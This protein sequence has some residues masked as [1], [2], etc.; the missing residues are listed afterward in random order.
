MINRLEDDLKR[1]FDLL[2]DSI[3]YSSTDTLYMYANTFS[4]IVYDNLT[5][6]E[7]RSEYVNYLKVNIDKQISKKRDSFNF[8]KF[9]RVEKNKIITTSKLKDRK[10]S[11]FIEKKSQEVFTREMLESIEFKNLSFKKYKKTY[12]ELPLTLTGVASKGE[13]YLDMTLR[14]LLQLKLDLKEKAKGEPNLKEKFI[15]KETINRKNI[16]NEVYKSFISVS[17]SNIPFKLWKSNLD[18]SYINE[19]LKVESMK[20]FIDYTDFINYLVQRSYTIYNRL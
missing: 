14:E 9:L 8:K 16:L 2:P 7:N 10:M 3:H 18:T 1:F 4:E 20:V 12:E 15:L 11:E 19:C 5:N 6:L 17:Q 13:E